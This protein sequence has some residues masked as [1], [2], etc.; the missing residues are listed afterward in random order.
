MFPNLKFTVGEPATLEKQKKW[1]RVVQSPQLALPDSMSLTDQSEVL[2]LGSCFV[3]EIRSVLERANLTVHPTIDPELHPLFIDDV[4]SP[5]AWGAWDE[6]I[7]YQ[8]FT[9]FTI[10]Q[11]IEVACGVR[12]QDP[13]AIFERKHKGENVFIDPYR[14]NVYA[15]S[16]ENLL[17][18]RRRMNDRV[19]T[20]LEKCQ[21][22]IMTLGL[23]EAFRIPT[24][25][26]YLS[27]YTTIIGDEHIEFVTASYEQ[28]FGAMATTMDLIRHRYPTKPVVLTVSP[29]PLNRT[30]SDV[31]AITATTRSKSI[32]RTVV[33]SLQRR[34]EHVHY[35]PSYEYAMW[36]GV[37]FRE[38]D[39][40]HIRPEA[41]DAI[42]SA[43]CRSFFTAEISDRIKASRRIDAPHQNSVAKL[44]KRLSK[45]C[46]SLF[47]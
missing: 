9:P 11:E 18:I 5:P 47:R 14:R 37:A 27:E 17:E 22:I 34:Y 40:R 33:D 3:N 1:K 30:F 7:H 12:E 23:V 42:T 43:F 29:I 2:A 41:V 31:D 32:L 28:A 46:V 8:C 25:G 21:L 44:F 38:D 39:M 36:S 10:Q 16:R 19:R 35:W 24:F 15:A 26:A 20:G 4:K 45:N 6:R 13:D